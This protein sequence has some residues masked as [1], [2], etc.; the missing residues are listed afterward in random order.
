MMVAHYDSL[1]PP[2]RQTGTGSP[3]SN[4]CSPWL[5]SR[6]SARLGQSLRPQDLASGALQ[7]V[8]LGVVPKATEW[9]RRADRLGLGRDHGVDVPLFHGAID[10][11]VG[12]ARV[13]GY[14]GH[15]CAG[16]GSTCSTMCWPSFNSP[17]VTSTSRMTP[18][19]VVHGSVLL[20]T[21]L[22][23]AITAVR[24]H[25]RLGI[26]GADLLEFTCLAAALRGVVELGRVRRFDAREVPRGQAL[27]GYIGGDQ[28]GV[29]VHDLSSGDLCHQAGLN[30]S[31][32]DAAETIS[33][34]TLAYA[35]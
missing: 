9:D 12:V 1:V 23:P 31:F 4:G 32:E 34:P 8:V 17:V 10:V 11:A 28:G 19:L 15:R 2:D 3:S 7:D 35:G 5:S 27:P 6:R 26:G 20:I 25:R 18:A 33:A 14:R 22:K 21:R 30:G 24:R 13:G 29:D 16:P